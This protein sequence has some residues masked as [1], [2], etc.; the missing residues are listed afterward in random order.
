VNQLDKFFW[1]IQMGRTKLENPMAGW[2]IKTVRQLEGLRMNQYVRLCCM[3]ILA[4]LGAAQVQANDLLW[5]QPPPVSNNLGDANYF[6]NTTSTA[7]VAP[8]GT[9][10]L[11]IGAGGN[12]TQA[13]NALSAQKLRVGNVLGAATYQGAGTL[14]VNNGAQVSLTL[15]GSG[16]NASLIIG[17]GAASTANSGF[18]GTLNIDG[19]GSKVTSAQLVQIGF[20]DKSTANATVNIT[21]G[22]SLVATTGNM[23]LG[24]RNGTG[25]G[26]PGHLNISG[27]GSGLTIT[28]ASADLNIGVRAASSYA[29]TDGIVSIGD[30]INVGQNAAA[31]SSFSLSGGTLTAGGAITV[32]DNTANGSSFTVSGGTLTSASVTIGS[33]ANNVTGSITGNAIVKAITNNLNVGLGASQG[34]SLLVA[35]NADIDISNTA[36]NTGNVFVGRDTSTNATFTMTGG[37]IHT[38]RNFLLGNATGA[39]GIVGNQS[40]GMI[41]TTLNFVV[42][43]TNGAATYNLSGT[44]AIVSN[45]A[46]IVGRQTSTGVMNQ[47]GGSVTSALG[48]SVGNAQS[49]TTTL[50]GTGTYN[51]SGGTITTNQTTGLALS[52]GPQG[53]GTFRVIGDDS[54]INV[55]GNMTVN[56]GG[57]AQGTLAYRLETGDL[58]SEINVTGT[59]TFNAG[60]ILNFD[61]SLASPTQTSYDLLTAAS[62]VD[63]GIS[64]NGPAGW[65]YQVVTG[66]LGQILQVAQTV[67][68]GLPGDF[69]SDGKVD[70]GDYATWRKNEVANAALANDNGVGNQAARFTLWRAN[71]GNPPGAG[72]SLQGGQVPEPASLM[73]VLVGAAALVGIRRR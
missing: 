58:L 37:K 32:G 23:N 20:G 59:A 3:V 63:S 40:G 9:D 35:D 48:V 71:F 64:F 70:A 49:A 52:I 30:Q 28:A 44:G 69:N 22:G 24:E 50:W 66:G 11:F 7:N 61:T 21:N 36:A 6:D 31:N 33:V 16:A 8:A 14:T 2:E 41:T 27:A 60:A 1:E 13:T 17:G 54:T 25:S 51:V 26:V 43:D 15:A 65:A 12:V 5:Q 56:A 53:T 55:N 62:I 19:T 72:A 42:T 4:A 39:T 57:G 34:A 73:L 47:T 38:G 46:V 29:Q 10:I 67:A 68:P 18:D 45:G